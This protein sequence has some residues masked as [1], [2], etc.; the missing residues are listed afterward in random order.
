MGTDEKINTLAITMAEMQGKQNILLMVTIA[1]FT[2]ILTAVI[3][4]V[5]KVI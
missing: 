3:A 4:I 1:N 5:M 2:A